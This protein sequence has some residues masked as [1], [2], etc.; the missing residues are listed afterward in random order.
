MRY[1]AARDLGFVVPGDPLAP[2]E[3]CVAGTVLVLLARDQLTLT[4]A[5]G[6]ARIADPKRLPDGVRILPFRWHDR[7]RFLRLGTEAR[8]VLSDDPIPLAAGAR[9]VQRR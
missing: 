3:V 5:D 1:E 2:L 9:R 6:L 8:P 7:V 4:E